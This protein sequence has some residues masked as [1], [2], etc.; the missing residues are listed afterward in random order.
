LITI[1]NKESNYLARVMQID[2]VVEIPGA[3]TLQKTIID[4]QEVAISKDIKVGDIVVY[5]PAG[6]QIDHEYL[7]ATN[8]FAKKELNSDPEV[9]GYFNSK[10]LVKAI[11]LMKGQ[12]KSCGYVV[13]AYSYFK[14]GYSV[15]RLT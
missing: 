9:S 1:T 2:N 12:I 3:R 10:G 13:P 15:Q 5:F 4:F 6:A 11:N 7:S 14:E 8:S